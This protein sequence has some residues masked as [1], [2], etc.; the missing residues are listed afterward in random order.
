MLFEDTSDETVLLIQ[1]G[2]ENGSLLK[3]NTYLIGARVELLTT[4][5]IIINYYHY[6][7]LLIVVVI[8]YKN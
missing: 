4:Y 7:Y 1:K 6:L 2:I 5:H 8:L 3:V